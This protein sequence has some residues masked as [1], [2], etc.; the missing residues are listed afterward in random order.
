MTIKEKRESIGM[1]RAEM[2]RLLKIPIRTLE[3][4]DSEKRTPPEWAKLLILE[5]LDAIGQERQGSHAE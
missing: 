2:S 3:D 1:S 4:W 5:K